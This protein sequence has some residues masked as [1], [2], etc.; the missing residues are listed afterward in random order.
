L[1]HRQPGQI[2]AAHEPDVLRRETRCAGKFFL[3]VFRQPFHHLFAVA[4]GLLRLDN[5][6]TDVPIKPNQLAVD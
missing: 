3:E 6:F 4:L 2:K 1:R 5:D